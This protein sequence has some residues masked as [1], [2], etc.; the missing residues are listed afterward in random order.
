MPTVNGREQRCLQ[1]ERELKRLLRADLEAESFRWEI[2][3][4]DDK[5]KVFGLPINA[6][7]SVSSSQVGDLACSAPL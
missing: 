4:A 7:P 2:V 1:V 6:K 5:R 3:Q